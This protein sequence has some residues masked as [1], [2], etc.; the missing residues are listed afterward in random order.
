LL[1]LSIIALLTL[2]TSA[3]AYDDERT[4]ATLKGIDKVAV[5]IAPLTAEAERDGLSRSMLQTDVELRLRQAGI[6]VVQEPATTPVLY[7]RVE[8]FKP[9][10]NS[11]YAY[12]VCVELH[13]AV[14]LARASA[15]RSAV[16]T[17]SVEVLGTVGEKMMLPTLR[18]SVGDRVDRF[19][20][21]YVAVNPKT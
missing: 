18:D 11:S 16:P 10:D 6:T 4:R 20:N 2:P 15:I 12:T 13:Q 5:Q 3:A 1:A 17:W 7:V 21:A 9:R 8:T 14:S 19:I